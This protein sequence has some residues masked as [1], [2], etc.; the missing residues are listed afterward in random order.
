MSRQ[1]VQGKQIAQSLGACPSLG[2]SSPERDELWLVVQS[3]VCTRGLASVTP[4]G[5]DASITVTHEQATDELISAMEWLTRHEDQARA[6]QPLQ[7]FVRLRGVATRGSHGS[8]RAARADALRGITHVVPG[9]P[10]VWS[11]ADPSEVAS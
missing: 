5:S 10:V 3:T 4:L 2:S 11:D 9:E 7:L 8:G 6:M 1:E